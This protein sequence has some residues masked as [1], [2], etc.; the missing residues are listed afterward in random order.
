MQ[1]TAPRIS[2]IVYI[3]FVYSLWL[4]S[5]R[6]RPCV[7]RSVQRDE[8]ISPGPVCAGTRVPVPLWADP[9]RRDREPL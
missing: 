4:A 5:S 7:F 1:N 9:R 8:S 6:L 3:P 2:S